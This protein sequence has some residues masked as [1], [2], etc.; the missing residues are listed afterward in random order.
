MYIDNR[1]R[2]R[3]YPQGL[4]A[5]IIIAPPHAEEVVIEGEVVDM[6]YGGIKIRLE[7]PLRPPIEEAALRITLV[8]PESGVSMSIHGSIRHV[9]NFN[10]CGLQYASH[11]TESEMD[12][13]MFECVKLAPCFGDD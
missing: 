5:H 3:F 12:D 8:L 6:S 7:K 4:T 11:H 1:E 9:E 10:E 13:M 2:K